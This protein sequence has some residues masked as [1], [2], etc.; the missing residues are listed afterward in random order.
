MS[1]VISDASPLRALHHLELLSLCVELYGSII[2]PDQVRSE[3][4]KPTLT[5]PPFDIASHPGFEIRR[6]TRP[7][8]PRI[9][10][11]L[12]PGE[13]EAIALAIE[14][15]AQLLLIDERKADQAAKGLGLNTIGVLGV[16]LNAKGQSLI[17]AVL[18]LVD[19]L[20]HE[21]NFFISRALRQHIA[22]L[23]GE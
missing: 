7:Y 20:T 13:T 18:P 14:L 1:V 21:L 12:D 5:C 3:L 17:P 19:R 6:A 15:G 9:P 23:S 16:L 11:D 2:V 22:T 4:L 8:P 10:T